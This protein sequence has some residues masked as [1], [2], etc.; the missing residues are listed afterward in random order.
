MSA[1]T[2]SAG[3]VP[4]TPAVPA[5]QGG[6]LEGLRDGLVLAERNLRQIPRIPEALVFSTIQPI[7]FVALFAYVFG[8]AIPVPG[9]SYR[10]FLMAGVFTQTMAFATGAISVGIAD[11]LQKGL[12]DRFRSLPIARSAVLGGRT[13]AEMVRQ[14]VILVIMMVT[15]LVVGWRVHDGVLSFLGAV[16][17]LMLLAYAMSWV[18]AFIGLAVPNAETANVAGFIWLFPLT[19]L[20]NAFVPPDSLPGWLQPIAEW[21]PISATVSACRD[22]FGNP[23][24]APVEW[25][26]GKSIGWSLVILLLFIPLSVR[27]Y[28]RTAGR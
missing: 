14:L 1:P 4:A 12:I 16:A 18:G 13:A 5:S 22:L 27:R 24:P 6:V 10:E 28:R 19:F 3:V 15:G 8:G 2:T 17:L 26:V 11:D 25:A 21:N 7:V 20:S 9:G 23:N